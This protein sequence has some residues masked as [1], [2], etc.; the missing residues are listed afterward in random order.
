MS[1]ELRNFLHEKG[2]ATSHTTPYNPQGNGQSEVYNGTVWKAI[3]LALKSKRL[4]T[5]CWQDVLPDVLYSIRSLLCTST[6]A[7]PHERMFSYVRRPTVGS[8]IPTWLMT[9]GTVLLKQHVRAH[10]CEPLV[11]EVELLEANP[12][13][14]HVRL[15][16]GRETTVSHRH[17][18]PRGDVSPT[19]EERKS[20]PQSSSKVKEVITTPVQE[21]GLE[22]LTD[23]SAVDDPSMSS[24]PTPA[25]SPS[26]CRS[27]RNWPL[28]ERLM[29]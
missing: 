1:T 7:T 9:P 18:A 20:V 11:D 21:T 22:A 23:T 2:I 6:N 4:P 16:D 14:A 19:M 27:K 8:S 12:Q 13:Y 25:E 28:P 29:L 10:K 24:R 3:T 26:L 15:P 17:L 5:S